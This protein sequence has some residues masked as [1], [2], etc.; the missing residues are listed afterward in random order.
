M[1]NRTRVEEKGLK[2][3]LHSNQHLNQQYICQLLLV[4]NEQR[5]IRD[6]PA[7]YTGLARGDQRS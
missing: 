1:D 3:Y 7:R 2:N 4:S 5:L 6:W